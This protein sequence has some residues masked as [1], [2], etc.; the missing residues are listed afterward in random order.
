MAKALAERADPKA[1]LIA[2][3]DGPWAA[4]ERTLMGT[5]QEAQLAEGLRRSVAYGA[6]WQVIAQQVVLGSLALSPKAAAWLDSKASEN[7]K[8]NTQNRSDITGAQP[9]PASAC[10]W[11]PWSV[12]LPPSTN[13]ATRSVTPNATA[14][15]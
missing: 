4:P 14:A 3:R 12:S 7:A 13:D 10:A 15:R 2:F 5:A 1:A 9:S 11:P 8:K 6:R